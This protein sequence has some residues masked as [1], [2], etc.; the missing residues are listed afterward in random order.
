MQT[1]VFDYDLP[2]ELI[3]QHP[4]P[5][6]AMSRMMVLR[7][8]T[9]AI[10][11]ARAGRLPEFLR[12]GDALIVNDTRVIPARVFGRRDD[13][14]G[15]VE[16]LLLRETAPGL[17]EAMLRMSGAPRP[18][19]RLT[20]GNGRIRATVREKTGAGRAIVEIPAG[21]PL[22][23]VL[24]EVG[25]M[26]LPPYIRRPR[27][28]EGASAE[29]RERYQTVYA[30]HAGAVAAPTAGLHLSAAMLD[31]VRSGGVHVASITL[32]V[33]PGTFR[34]VKS[35]DT[36]D[37]VMEAEFYRV[38]PEAAGAV[39]EARGRGGRVVAVGTT[40]VRT[41]EAV[42]AAHE[43]EVT[44]CEGNTALFIRPPYRFLATDAL[45]TNFHL[46][47]STLLML[48]CAFAGV[49]PV[50]RAYRAAVAEGYR[51]YSYGDCMLIV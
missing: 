39:R 13:T 38:G 22:P 2:R 42:A 15:R 27:G 32:H 20:L 17:W 3:A 9:G 8:D 7:R 6:R 29:D 19:M 40:T 23:D 24:D 49:E 26:P 30:R 25:S 44:P 14:G 5:E 33:G 45:L 47:R 48:V 43:G 12:A 50:L 16:A 41:L 1:S 37:H 36:N 18:G 46:P 21:K 11:H 4:L 31:A 34:P 51:F 28:G 10:A 35:N